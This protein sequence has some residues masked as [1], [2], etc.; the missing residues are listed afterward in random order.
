MKKFIITLILFIL[1][2]SSTQASF[3]PF[4]NTLYFENKQTK[5]IKYFETRN[6]SITKL[7]VKYLLNYLDQ[8]KPNNTKIDNLS[9]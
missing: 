2:L 7:K 1:G 9:Y 8:T 3:Y 6:Y 5:E 4:K